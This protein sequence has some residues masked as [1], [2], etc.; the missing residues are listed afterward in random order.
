MRSSCSHLKVILINL[1]FGRGKTVVGSHT[2]HAVGAGNE[3]VR[4]R[5]DHSAVV[6]PTVDEVTCARC[7]PRG[8]PSH[9]KSQAR[10]KCSK[11][12]HRRRTA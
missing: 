5:V 9:G 12:E 7:G 1:M 4:A 10:M 2:S 11:F 6:E 8:V 3:A